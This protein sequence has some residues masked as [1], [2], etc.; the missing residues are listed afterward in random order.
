M[1][2]LSNRLPS[3]NST[4]FLLSASLIW[5]LV[6]VNH[7][8]A[9]DYPPTERKEVGTTWKVSG[10]VTSAGTSRPLSNVQVYLTY[11]SY[12]YP[13]RN[14]GNPWTRKPVTTDF[15]G[16]FEIDVAENY[17]LL[18]V[19]SGFAPLQV[20][21][22]DGS[23]IDVQLERGRTISGTIE[24][25]LGEPAANAVVTPVSWFVPRLN[26]LKS[27]DEMPGYAKNH[28]CGLPGFGAN[29]AVKTDADGKFAIHNMPTDFRVGL[30]V[31]SDGWKEE[32][33]FVRQEDDISAEDYPG[34]I[35]KEN[36]FTYSLE[37][38]SR[39][40]ISATDESSNPALIA[41][42]STNPSSEFASQLYFFRSE[43]FSKAHA[44][45]SVWPQPKGSIA[46]IEPVESETLLGVRIELPPNNDTDVIE[47][48]IE[49]PRG[50]TIRGIVTS[51]ETGEPIEGVGI[52]WTNR[53]K[54]GQYV[55]G[56]LFPRWDV[57]TDRQG[58]F[59]F[60]VPDVDGTIQVTGPV[61]GFQTIPEN[62]NVK[63]R[64]SKSKQNF[65][66]GTFDNLLH[67]LNEGELGD[68]GLIEFQL[69][70]SI[71]LD[72]S[73]IDEK[74]EPVPNGVL[75]MVKKTHIGFRFD[76][77]GYSS[78]YSTQ[79][80]TVTTDEEGVARVDNA[81]DDAYA[82]AEANSKARLPKEKQ[83][84]PND[85]RFYMNT[86]AYPY[87]IQAFSADGF[88]QGHAFT[89]LPESDSTVESIPMTISLQRGGDVA[90]RVLTRD[91]IPI[92][93]LEVSAHSGSPFYASQVWST[94]TRSDGK[95]KLQGL[96]IESSLTWYLDATRVKT[97][98]SEGAVTADTSELAIGRTLEI[99]PF[100]C[101][102]CSELAEELPEIEIGGLTSDA[103]LALLEAYTNDC[104]A[105]IPYGFNDMEGGSNSDPAPAYIQR[106]AEKTWPVIKELAD[107]EPG[108][109]FELRLLQSC[110]RTI[111]QSPWTNYAMKGIELKT[112]VARRL[113]TNHITREEA[114]KSIIASQRGD[115]IFESHKGWQQVYD[116]SPFERTKQV[117][118]YQ[119]FMGY[120]FNLRAANRNDGAWKAFEEKLAKFDQ[121]L[122]RLEKHMQETDSGFRK[123]MRLQIKSIID[124]LER[125]LKA[126]AGEPNQQTLEL[127][128]SRR[129]KITQ[130]LASLQAALER[131][132]A[133]KKQQRSASRK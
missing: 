57:K 34:Q 29:W 84:T 7:S 106:V 20:P 32:V 58:K 89:P 61:T 11:G 110:Q 28:M 126:E 122:A 12:Y 117:A 24:M 37:P 25:P 71:G 15:A 114:Q 48:E 4:L 112:F 109:D 102:D 39:L 10:T 8:S 99:K 130:T 116:A 76:G 108:S 73:V 74:G 85:Y 101:I 42:I 90:G 118:A 22:P 100:V 77:Q 88:R 3:E 59:T 21:V 81:Y 53:K 98:Q 121:S 86:E 123:G 107:R 18:F 23:A 125:Q 111:L 49:F 52:R 80:T 92:E 19:T 6:A 119:M 66:T 91:D 132:D 55:A 105:K 41:R 36:E 14:N 75:V 83:K 35:L 50:K 40:E 31:K 64:N 93:G 95:F 54:P 87:S 56:V 44:V 33:V 124:S 131:M 129:S 78:G 96:P 97:S 128:G 26:P 51:Q 133:P 67:E 27:L 17:Q 72:V 9:Q 43:E 63:L 38:C 30:S 79:P 13:M 65:P 69:A 2:V 82:L 45:L 5:L 47:R 1:A 60:A 16:R 46:F 70:P 104:I 103:A 94:R 120:Y 62:L 127:S 68:L 113:L 115:H